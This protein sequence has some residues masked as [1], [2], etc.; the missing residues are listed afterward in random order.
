MDKIEGVPEGWRLVRIG[1]PKVGEWIVNGDG[2]ATKYLVTVTNA[3]KNHSIIERIEPP[4]PKYRPFANAAEFEPHRNLWVRVKPTGMVAQPISY[5][6]DRLYI[7]DFVLYW[8]DAFVDLE[9][10]SGTPFGV[11][12]VELFVPAGH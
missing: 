11:E 2:C 4:K 6:Q 3:R 12:V 10:E 9:F 5:T 7:G 8:G 1:E